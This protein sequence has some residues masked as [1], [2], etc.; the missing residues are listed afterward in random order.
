MDNDR[1]YGDP[2]KGRALVLKEEM[3]N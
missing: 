2:P 1:H 3:F